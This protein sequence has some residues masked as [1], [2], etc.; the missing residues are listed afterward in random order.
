M[1]TQNTNTDMEETTEK[2]KNGGDGL[3]WLKR[4]V[5]WLIVNGGFA[6]LMYAALAENVG[7]AGNALIF[8]I[9]V[10]AFLVIMCLLSEEVRKPIKDK[11]PTVPLWIDHLYDLAAAMAFAAFGWYWSATVM[12][13]SLV[14]LSI[15]HKKTK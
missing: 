13:L 5:R 8:W 7:W 15:T 1:N 4:F 2:T 12:L 10:Q 9:N 11:G 14:M 6:W 3:N